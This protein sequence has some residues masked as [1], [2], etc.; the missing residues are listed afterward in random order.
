MVFFQLIIILGIS[1]SLFKAQVL[2]SLPLTALILLLVITFFTFVGMIIGYIFTSE[3]TSTLAA[4]SIGSIFLFLS[5][6]IMPLETMPETIRKI[7]AFNPFV[8]GESL[9]RKSII[10]Q[11]NISSLAN[12]LLIL[13]GYSIILFLIIWV[14]QRA[15]RKHLGHKILYK[16]HKSRKS[17]KLAKAKNK[18]IK[19]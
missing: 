1:A 2:T 10:F 17:K 19:K 7:A 12:E 6:V 4:I 3:E 5:N 16:V 8:I 11:S 14:F 18:K 9:L 13:L 15:V